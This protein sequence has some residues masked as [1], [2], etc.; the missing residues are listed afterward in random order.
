MTAVVV[1]VVSVVA[2]AQFFLSYVRSL[3][4]AYNGMDFSPQAQEAAGIAGSVPAAE[5][6]GRI[7]RLVELCPAPATES[8]DLRVIRLYFMALRPLTALGPSLA[9]W[10][11]QER[12]RCTYSAVVALDRRLDYTRRLRLGE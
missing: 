12:R 9:N 3:V 1:T 7:F 2:L 5:E 11:V 4:D 8:R 6:F 10:A